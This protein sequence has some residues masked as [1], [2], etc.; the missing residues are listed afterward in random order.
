[1]A[2]PRLIET[3]LD[4]GLMQNLG[5][6][7]LLTVLTAFSTSLAAAPIAY[8][9]NSDSGNDPVADSLY[10]IDLADG[11]ETRVATVTAFGQT[12]LDVEGLAFAAD[13]T[14]YGVDETFPMSLFA[15]NPD[16]ATVQSSSQVFINGLPSTS[17]NDF[18]MTFACD[19]N[20]YLTSV[21][22]KKLYKMDLEGN[23]VEVGSLG[24]GTEIVAIAAIGN[25]VELYG[26]GKGTTSPSLYS[27][28]TSTGTATKIGTT[29]DA[30]GLAVTEY[31]EGGL[32]FDDS[33]E[34]WAIT[35]TRQVS[36]TSSGQTMHIDRSLGRAVEV[37]DTKE[38][39]FESLAITVPRG[40][41]F[42]SEETARFSVQKQYVDGNDSTPATL[43][44]ACNTGFIN[45]KSVTVQPNEGEFGPVE[46]QFLV[47]GFG[48]DTLNCDI[49]ESAPLNYSATYQCISD[50]SCMATADG[51]TFNDVK[52]GQ[53][54]MCLVRN[55]PADAQ[56]T[57]S[58]DWLFGA[59]SEGS[60]ES[61]DV[62]LVCNP[63]YNGDGRWD[64]SA[65]RW[66]W[67]FGSDSA[68]QLATFQP[69]ANNSR[70]WTEVTPENS[71]IESSSSCEKSTPV[72]PG[73]KLTCVITNTIFFEGIPTLSQYGL[74]L[75]SA[76]MML[77][78]LAAVRRF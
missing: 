71:S 52:V 65:M 2:I 77:T 67:Q 39:G 74:L 75:F 25:P 46:T 8:S 38:Q 12:Q 62:D 21:V 28:S 22:D 11:T 15:I 73:D 53:F 42:A 27:I 55:Y 37:R 35:D 18:G 1:M 32:A 16:N 41:S 23:T 19:G 17:G 72:L 33:N 30:G 24:A 26:L 44:I 59:G 48:D 9:I 13:G 10:R 56:V 14:L 78:G 50:A 36:L 64:G 29:L 40:C 60:G 66:R 4:L 43:N 54:N 58:A 47:K 7:I 76:L 68:D 34:L 45:N 61:V 69:M 63:V 51:C 5:K 70:C 6:T 31:G 57:V 20:L 49:S 3:R